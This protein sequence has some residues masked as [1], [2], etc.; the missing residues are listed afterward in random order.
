MSQHELNTLNDGSHHQDQPTTSAPS[1]SQDHS[2]D[3]GA[4]MSK[5]LVVVIVSLY[6]GTFLVALDTMI[7]GTA[8]PAI[9][10]DFHALDDLAW[11]GSAYLLT[12][13]ALQPTFGKLYKFLDTKFL[14]LSS[15]ALFEGK[16]SPPTN[17]SDLN[18]L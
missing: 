10:T 8:L 18:C 17:L 11:Y 15:I 16:I 13:T 6:M 1:P 5:K 14:Y 12:F 7:I 3:R 4:S 2:E 9:T